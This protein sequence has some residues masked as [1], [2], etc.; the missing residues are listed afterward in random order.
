MEESQVCWV[1]DSELAYLQRILSKNLTKRLGSELTT[2]YGRI[3]LAYR[4]DEGEIV[5]VE[6]ERAIDSDAKLQHA[7]EQVSRY[8]R[9][10]GAS[11]PSKVSVV[12]M[13][14]A[15]GTPDRYRREIARRAGELEITVCE[16][17]MIQVK[18]LY[19]KLMDRVML[20]AGTALSRPVALGVSSLSWLSKIMVVYA[21]KQ[22]DAIA[23]S[24]LMGEYNS[25]TN[26]YVL[27]RLAEDFELIT[28][29]RRAKTNYLRLTTYGARYVE[30]IPGNSLPEFLNTEKTEDTDPDLLSPVAHRKL[31]IEIL[32]NNNYTKTKVNIFHFL[33]Y[34]N[35]TAGE[36]L[37]KRST[38]FSP[39]ELQY[40][41]TFL[42][43]SY[44]VQT[45]KGHFMQVYKY[46]HE[47]GMIER[48]ACRG[49]NYDK[50]ILTS[51]GSR[52]LGCFE[53]SLHLARERNQIPLQISE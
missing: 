2:S 14:A 46:C 20:N 28:K 35:M 48:I 5:L 24:D 18:K 23:W 45:L 22:T 32:L 15:E 13:Y 30:A 27:K 40:L 16:Y 42:G 43:S 9:S 31:L 19:D 41:N 34:I 6:L 50:A 12:L 25:T 36:L 11:T 47:L 7:L 49:A 53:L 26:F 39:D 44:N 21:Q 10:A 29:H 51:L 38:M 33:R 8:S 37:P 1:L 17:S 4:T 52:V 3:D